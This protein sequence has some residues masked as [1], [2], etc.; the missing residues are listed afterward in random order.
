MLPTVTWERVFNFVVRLLIKSW[1]YCIS[2]DDEAF[3]KAY[4]GG[5]DELPFELLLG[6]AE[7][8]ILA[9]LVHSYIS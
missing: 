5:L 4:F 2:L 7:L 6:K 9:D 3:T 8:I 1:D